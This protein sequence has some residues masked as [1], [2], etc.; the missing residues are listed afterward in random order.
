MQVNSALRAFQLARYEAREHS[1]YDLNSLKR[2]FLLFLSF[3]RYST[4]CRTLG[5]EKRR[6]EASTFSSKTH[7]VSCSVGDRNPQLEF[8]ID[9][10]TKCQ[11]WAFPHYS[12]YMQIATDPYPILQ[13]LWNINCKQ[14]VAVV[15]TRQY[16]TTYFIDSNLPRWVFLVKNTLSALI[17]WLLDMHAHQHFRVWTAK[18]AKHKKKKKIEKAVSDLLWFMRIQLGRH[19][20]AWP[21]E[22]IEKIEEIEI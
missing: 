6:E 1:R 12:S 2:F 10:K 3:V 18:Q 8:Q 16:P 5:A 7:A 21:L 9:C 22:Q 14:Y 4:V 13:I 19:G 17:S 20:V 15:V 11:K